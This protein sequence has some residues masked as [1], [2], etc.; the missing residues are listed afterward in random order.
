LS[1]QFSGPQKDLL[2]RAIRQPNRS[3]SLSP[4]PNDPP[5]NVRLSAGQMLKQQM[6]ADGVTFQH[7]LGIN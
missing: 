6:E 2:Q 1:Q 4:G 5:Q 3:G 7:A